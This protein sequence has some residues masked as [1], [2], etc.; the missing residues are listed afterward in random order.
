MRTT[1][2]GRLLRACVTGDAWA[3]PSA[4]VVRSARSASPALVAAGAE[5]HG[6]S[7]YVTSALR[8][9]GTGPAI[10]EAVRPAY[11]R[12]IFTH[13]QALADL[14]LLDAALR[15]HDVPFACLLY[16]SPSPR[17]S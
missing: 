2:A 14:A 5:F 10:V 6:V 3:T 17:D 4:E 9:A 11:Y 15:A 8:A 13:L 16:T 12:G 7:G 1:P